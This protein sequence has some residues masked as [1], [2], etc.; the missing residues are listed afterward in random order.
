MKN[1]YFQLICGDNQT[2]LKIIAPQEGGNPVSVK[3]VV[4]YLVL[5]GVKH[6][7]TA[8]NKGIQ[9]ALIGFKSRTLDRLAIPSLRSLLPQPRKKS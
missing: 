3:E 6:D 2:A 9:D 7:L 8:G 1:G 4:E 5:H